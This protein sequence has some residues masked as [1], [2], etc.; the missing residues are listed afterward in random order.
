MTCDRFSFRIFCTAFF[1]PEFETSM[2]LT[3]TE[4]IFL[5]T[6]HCLPFIS[7]HVYPRGTPHIIM[8]GYEHVTNLLPPLIQLFLT[9]QN[10]LPCS[11]TTFFTRK[12]HLQGAAWQYRFPNVIQNESCAENVKCVIYWASFSISSTTSSKSFWSGIELN[13]RMGFNTAVWGKPSCRVT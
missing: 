13:D 2:P 11:R 6:Q 4:G 3:F 8:Q 1:E 7:F 9:G 12:T 10:S 5:I